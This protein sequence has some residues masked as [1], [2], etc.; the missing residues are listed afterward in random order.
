MS[1]NTQARADK[2]PTLTIYHLEM[3]RSIRIVWTC[4]ELGLPYRLVFKQGDLMGS[5]ALLR[6][7]SPLMPIV[8]AVDLDG[9]ILIESGAILDLLVHRYGGGRLEP[10]RDSADYPYHLQWLHFAEGTAM[11]RIF[12]QLMASGMQ[13]GAAAENPAASFM[14]GPRAVFAFSEE[15][16]AKHPYFGGSEFST[17]DIMMHVAVKAGAYAGLKLAD[18]PSL[19][20]WRTRVEARPAFKRAMDAALPGGYDEDG[21]AYGLPIPGSNPPAVYQR[22]Q[23]KG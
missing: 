8:P 12:A 21:N 15:F 22:P 20:A 3:R 10:A 4:E 17:A 19:S 23:P 16:I 13:R 6:A 14:V 18:Y 2:M 7:A 11:C 5:M 9:Q 1:T